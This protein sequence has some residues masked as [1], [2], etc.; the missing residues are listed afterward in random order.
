MLAYVFWHSPA[1]P[2]RAP[3]YEERLA[4]FHRALQTAKPDGFLRSTAYR[5]H[6]GSWLPGAPGYEDWY[7]V[8][9]WAAL[10]VL[11]CGG[12][13]R[14]RPPG[15][16][17]RRGAGRRRS[18]RPLRATAPRVHRSGKPH[19]RRL[20]GQATRR[21]LSRLHCPAR[22]V[23]RGLRAVAA[24]DGPRADSRVLRCGP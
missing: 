9:D 16:R 5:V 13:I 4:A 20:G 22:D 6:D 2:E 7:E 15:S 18:R 21:V 23:P 14:I 17:H 11:K 3:Q 8:A 1:V 24:A 12:R 10:G 19:P